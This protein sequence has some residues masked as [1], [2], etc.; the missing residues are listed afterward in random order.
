ML[1]QVLSWRFI[2]SLV[3]PAAAIGGHSAEKGVHELSFK[4]AVHTAVTDTSH[5]KRLNCLCFL[6]KTTGVQV[7]F[8]FM[9]ASGPKA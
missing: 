7:G 3:S 8:P 2:V 4:G 9:E 1:L 5:S 6:Q